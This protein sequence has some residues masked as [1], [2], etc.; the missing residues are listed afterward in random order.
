MQV[1]PFGEGDIGLAAADR[2]R[3]PPAGYFPEA[4]C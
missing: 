3:R 2:S 4:P 1:R